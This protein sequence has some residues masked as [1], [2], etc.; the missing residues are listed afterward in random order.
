VEIESVVTC[1][2][3]Y[4]T[5]PNYPTKNSGRGLDRYAYELIRGVGQQPGFD[6]YP[7]SA[8]A[9]MRD[10]LVREVETTLR[11]REVEATVYHA[12]SEYGLAS[13]VLARK[14]PIVVTIHDLLPQ[15]FFGYS[16]LTFANQRLHLRLVR[17]ADRVIT[18]SRFYSQLLQSNFNVSASRIDVVPYGVDHQV[19]RPTQ[20]R[21][22]GTPS[23]LL[24]L[25]GL[26]LLKGARDLIVAFELLS[27]SD[28]V[29]MVIG[30]RGK[31]AM[32]L[33]ETAHRLGIAGKITFTGLVE[34]HLL[35]GLYNSADVLVWPS[36]L[37]FG[38]STL[39]AMAC[40]TP[41]VGAKCLDSEEYLGEAAL[42]YAPGD[43]KQLVGALQY[44]LS[45]QRSWK[46]WST[47]AVEW[48]ENFSWSKMTEQVCSTY[49][50]LSR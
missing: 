18:T 34:E 29:R 31:H 7:V 39:E 49:E 28:D 12:T 26:N 40:G 33:K 45:S 9:S 2:V 24:Y 35:P 36:Y 23:T 41:V 25:G 20:D 32:L 8:E 10:Y 48:S 27:R 21:E 22:R 17:Y 50:D 37:G 3:C 14:K 46:N 44:A 6:V 13:L 1:D 43:V 15:L 42:L 11:L 30:G 4:V 16:P 47:R 19:F 38:L 5:F